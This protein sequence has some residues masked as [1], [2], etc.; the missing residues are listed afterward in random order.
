M[1]KKTLAWTVALVLAIGLLGFGAWKGYDYLMSRLVRERC[2]VNV[3]GSE[4]LQLTAEQSR[5]A[6]VIV[7]ASYKADLPA[8]AAV[9]AL[10]TAWQESGLRNLDYGDRDSLGLFQQRPSYGWGTEEQILDPWYSSGRFYEELVKFDD[11]E[12]RGITEMAQA[13][14]RSGHPDA[15]R[16]HEENAIALAGSLRGTRPASLSC[17]DRTDTPG[18]P[19]AFADVVAQVP[20]VTSTVDGTTVTLTSDDDAALWAATQLALAN[21]RLAG[22]ESAVMPGHTWRQ[23][24]TTTWSQGSPDGQPGVGTLKL[25]Q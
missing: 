6:A 10:A 9:I 14:Q 17:V 13:V 20:G 25:R 15:Y 1:S 18:D 8:Q 7:A 24:N 4:Q 2:Y 23:G 16:K 11:W 3:D 22:I 5:N 12:N 21:T 19:A